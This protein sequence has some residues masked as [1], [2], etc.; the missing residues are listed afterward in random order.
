MTD[1]FS[2]GH[3]AMS[4]FPPE[5]SAY[6]PCQINVKFPIRLGGH[7]VN[8]GTWTVRAEYGREPRRRRVDLIHPKAIKLCSSIVVIDR[9]WQKRGLQD[10]YDKGQEL[11]KRLD[12]CFV[13]E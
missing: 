2:A 9:F 1:N 10:L 12:E 5:E 8:F 3:W 4:F 13:P 6:D 7:P 11:S